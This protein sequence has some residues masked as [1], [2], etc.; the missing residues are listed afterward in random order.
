MTRHFRAEPVAD[1]VLEG[2]L[3]AARA[4]P[5]A[6]GT[7]GVD[8]LVLT[9][10]ERRTRFWELATEPAWRAGRSAAAL[11][12]APVIVVPVTD[13]GAYSERYARA[14]KFG[15]RLGGVAAAEWDVPYPIVDVAFATMLVLLAA[16][17]AGLG[18]LFFQLHA[19]RSAVLDGLGVPAGKDT[20]GAIALGYRDT[21][22]TTAPP[23]RGRRGF[24]QVIHRDTW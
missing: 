13:E 4:S 7:E 22:T 23:G 3:S 11:M 12:A 6:G 15:T 5:S 17:G 1:E 18:A 2:V 24:A 9:S 16:E 19:E 20:I 8:L 14:D 21:S 10:P